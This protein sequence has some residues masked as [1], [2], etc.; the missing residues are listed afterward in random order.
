MYSVKLLPEMIVQFRPVGLTLISS[1]CIILRHPKTKQSESSDA[2]ASII[3]QLGRTNDERDMNERNKKRTGSS[4]MNEKP[5]FMC[6]R[7]FKLNDFTGFH[8]YRSFKL[9]DFVG[10]SI[11]HSFMFRSFVHVSFIS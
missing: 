2:T 1:N 9:N 6:Y 3:P 10:T 7:S 8:F 5:K 4:L 11:I